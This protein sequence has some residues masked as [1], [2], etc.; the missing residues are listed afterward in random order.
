MRIYFDENI[1]PSLIRGLKEIQNGRRSEG[2][3]VLSIKEKFGKGTKDEEW[4]P[5][6]A[7]EHAIVVTQD[8]NI[9]RHKV[10]WELCQ[11][12]RLGLFFIQPPKKGWGYWKVVCLV[13]RLWPETKNLSKETKKPFGYVA[14]G[15]RYKWE[16]MGDS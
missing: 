9:R 12:Y 6:V 13:V 14:K 11:R 4:I 1:S 2:I 16:R 5:K 10:Q 8:F 7:Q 15:P 3:E